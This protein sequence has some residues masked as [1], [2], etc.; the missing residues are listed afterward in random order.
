MGGTKHG[1]MTLQ[2]V[3]DR[4]TQ[5]KVKHPTLEPVDLK[6]QSFEGDCYGSGLEIIVDYPKPKKLF[7][8]TQR[9]QGPR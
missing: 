8:K 6:I 9:R 2:E 5:E 1:V 4:F 3:L 7:D